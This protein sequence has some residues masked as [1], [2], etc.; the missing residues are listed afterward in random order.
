MTPQ[1]L[2][3][4]DKVYDVV[5]TVP[6]GSPG[7]PTNMFEPLVVGTCFPHLRFDPWQFKG[8]PKMVEQAKEL[9]SLQSTGEMDQGHFLRKL[10]AM[11]HKVLRMP[12]G[13][14]SRMLFFDQRH[15]VSHSAQ[16]GEGGDPNGI[17]DDEDR[18]LT[19]WR[20][21]PRDLNKHT[22]ARRGDVLMV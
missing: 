6:V 14:V 3:Q 10:W 5:F 1:W 2:E 11:C 13:M 8:S 7:W 22:R 15:S 19:I 16:G 12:E 20:Q 4:V 18:L 9:S 17:E 21:K